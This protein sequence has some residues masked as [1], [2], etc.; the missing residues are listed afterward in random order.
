MDEGGAPRE[1]RDVIEPRTREQVSALRRALLAVSVLD[2]VDLAPTDDGV[3][4]QVAPGDGPGPG[5]PGVPLSLDAATAVLG[6][7]APGS[8]EGHVRLS[9]WLRAH[10]A[11]AASTDPAGLLRRRV[12]ALALTGDAAL[13][14]A[15]G[16]GWARARVL[17]GLLVVGL[18]LV[19]ERARASTTP[20]WPDVAA[21][22]GVGEVALGALWGAAAEHALRMGA[23]SATRLQRDG[24]ERGV[25]RP[26]GGCDVLTL[27]AT[28]PVRHELATGDGTGMRT[29]AVPDRTRGWFDS[30]RV[31][32]VFISAAWAATPVADRGTAVPLLVTADEVVA[33]QQVG[34]AGSLSSGG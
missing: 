5:R 23:L 7:W 2:D 25:L 33:R 27:L 4:L 21:A 12:R 26:V 15:A 13:A 1:P 3:V 20:L 16:S 14:P 31:D 24:R 28:G 9:S 19:E 18:G 22:A 8:P 29:V 30:R 11:V 32:A 17:G 10:R 6:P 34:P